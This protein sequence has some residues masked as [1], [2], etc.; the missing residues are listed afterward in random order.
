MIDPY[1]THR[2]FFYVGFILT[3]IL[4]VSFIGGCGYIARTCIKKGPEGIG[5]EIGSFMKAID[6]GKK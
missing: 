1:K 5:K 3:F 6:E 2:R 4:C